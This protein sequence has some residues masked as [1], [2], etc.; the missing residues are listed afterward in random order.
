MNTLFKRIYRKFIAYKNYILKTYKYNEELYPNTFLGKKTKKE[1]DTLS[2]APKIIYIFWTG[3]NPITPNRQKGIDSLIK[4]A[5]VPVKLITPKNLQE[6]ILDDFPLHKAYQ[7]LSLNHR[8]DYLRAYFML[9]YGGG[10][11]DIKLYNKSWKRAF[12]RL[13]GNNDKWVIGY[14]EVGAWGIPQVGGKLESDLKRNYL[15][16]IGNGAFIYKP[17]SPIVKEWMYELHQRLDNYYELLKDNPATDIF[18][19]NPN[20][21]IPWAHLTGEIH[22][23]LVLKYHDKLLFDNSLKPS[24]KNYR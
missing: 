12:N 10:Y 9:H 14:R 16:L 19:K 4:N 13:N 5:K 2:S 17:H 3:D 7:Y 22:H 23:P 21:P 15:S 6:Y 18:G 8:S 24:F 11:A 1:I 20:Y